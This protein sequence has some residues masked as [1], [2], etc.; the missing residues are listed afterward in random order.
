MIPW[1][2]ESEKH[3]EAFFHEAETCTVL[4]QPLPLPLLSSVD[5]RDILGWRWLS[6]DVS[7][8][9]QDIF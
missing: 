5:R 4:F 6:D 9:G 7:D 3:K 2:H 8:M 1:S